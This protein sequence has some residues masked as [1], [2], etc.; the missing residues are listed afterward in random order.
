VT[1][2]AQEILV[3]DRVHEPEDNR[4]WRESYYFSFFDARHG[5]GG[6][7]SIGKRPKSGHSGSINVLWGPDMHTLVASE[8][9]SFEEHNDEFAAGGLTYSSDA[10]YGSWRLAFAGELNDGGGGVECDHAALGPTGRSA[11]PKVNVGY[12]LT[13]TP[14]GPPYIYPHRPEW[15]DLFTGHVDEIGAVEGRLTIGERSYDISGRAAKDHSWGVRDW[16]KPKAWRWIDVVAVPPEPEFALWR[17]SFDGQ[18]WVEDGAIYR[19]GGVLPV[20]R[21]SEQV[22]T[23]PRPRK[24]IPSKISFEAESGDTRVRADGRILRVVPIFFSRE[25][26]DERVVSWNDRTLVECSLGSGAPG[27][28]NVEFEEILREPLAE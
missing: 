7:S 11:A 8:F 10:P 26:G 13:F 28:A 27:W 22:E 15:R 18:T 14:G 1:D 6:F 2:L 23:Q 16:F 21:Y 12:E 20:A 4:R 25:E 5:I 19:D 9:D 3:H 24:P 17:A